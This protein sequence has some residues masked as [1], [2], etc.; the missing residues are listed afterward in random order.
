MDSSTC[1]MIRMKH[2]L[3]YRSFYKLTTPIK[4]DDP[5]RTQL[6]LIFPS[7]NQTTE[8]MIKRSMLDPFSAHWF[9]V[10]FHGMLLRNNA[11]AAVAMKTLGGL[12]YD[13]YDDFVKLADYFKKSQEVSLYS[14]FLAGDYRQRFSAFIRYFCKASA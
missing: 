12:K 3:Y 8:S 5:K 10:Y 13:S 14:I 4:R 6:D 1:K 11:T 9:N 7:L 2:L